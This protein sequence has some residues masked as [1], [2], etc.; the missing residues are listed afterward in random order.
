MV[1]TVLYVSSLIG[2]AGEMFSREAEG[3]HSQDQLPNVEKFSGIGRNSLSL[4]IFS[5]LNDGKIADVASFA[6]FM[7]CPCLLIS[8]VHNVHFHPLCRFQNTWFWWYSDFKKWWVFSAFCLF[9]FNHVWQSSRDYECGVQ[10]LHG[11]M[12]VRHVGGSIDMFSREAE[13]QHCTDRFTVGRNSLDIFSP[14][15]DGEG[16]FH[17]FGLYLMCTLTTV[18]IFKICSCLK[19]HQGCIYW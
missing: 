2:P 4:D 5:P 18:G 8:W 7:Y 10:W 15:R 16:T 3:Q 6:F 11:S 19:I 13:G 1:L 9:V 12:I 17:S 14:V